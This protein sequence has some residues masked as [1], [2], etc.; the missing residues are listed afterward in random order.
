[1]RNFKISYT[2]KGT[3]IVPESAYDD[4]DFAVISDEEAIKKVAEIEADNGNEGIHE[5]SNEN[6]KVELQIEVV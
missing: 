6:G 5:D 1:M 3:L 4:G 2:I